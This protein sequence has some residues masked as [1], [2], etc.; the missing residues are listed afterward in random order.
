VTDS[1]TTPNPSPGFRPGTA[2]APELVRRLGSGSAGETWRARLPDGRWVA[3]KVLA[4]AAAAA[5]R[6]TASDQGLLARLAHP[7]LVPVHAVLDQGE[8]L[9]VVRALAPG[10]TLRRL[11][12]VVELAPG[13]VAALGTGILEALDGLHRAGLHHGGVQPDN[14]WVDED[15]AVRMAD[16]AL[17]RAGAA[18]GRRAGA[19]GAAD[20]NAAD[21]AAA[22]GLLVAALEAGPQAPEAAHGS[23]LVTPGASQRPQLLAAARALVAL[24]D[25]AG[26][27]AG[28]SQTPAGAPPPTILADWAR[29]AG[30]LAD[31]ASRAVCLAELGAFVRR[32][33]PREPAGPDA[34]PGPAPDPRRAAVP[35]LAA[36]APAAAPRPPPVPAPPRHPHRA[37]R[38][39]AAAMAAALVL[40][41]VGAVVLAL[42]LGAHP[43][44]RGADQ[45]SGSRS[46]T[47]PAGAPARPHPSARTSAPTRRGPTGTS[48]R[49]AAAAASPQPA[50]APGR[51]HRAASLPRG[52]AP[53]PSLGPGSAG[54]V[55][56]VSMRTAPDGCTRSS[57]GCS[58]TIRIDLG[59]HPA[60]PI[61]W[62]LELVDACTGRVTP[63]PAGSY[64]APAPYTYVEA[65]ASVT[66]ATVAAGG[67]VPVAVVA[68][69]TFPAR[70]AAT[71]TYLVPPGA[72]CTA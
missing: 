70:A 4:P 46:P 17:P 2:T 24:G 30:P 34:M 64:T 57:A 36:Q 48:R 39:A 67:R 53:L 52:L 15:G 40:G 22:G 62:A 32:L 19:R 69:T 6:A 8:R 60:E 49:R 58:V 26:R 13:Q 44:P 37:G 27:T 47:V 28:G 29:A 25:R 16:A 68:V 12:S 55:Q 1:I 43:A 10:V 63:G 23:L 5:R 31:P 72:S 51:P 59:S 38:G 71:P 3:V 50:R 42:A 66:P 18:P 41:G 54:A 20:R 9:W 65:Q 33:R 7:R 45:P 61:G 35:T 14:I 21:L 56:R 11:R